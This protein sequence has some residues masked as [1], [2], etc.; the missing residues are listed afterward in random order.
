MGHPVEDGTMKRTKEQNRKNYLAWKA[1]LLD[2]ARL[3]GVSAHYGSAYG[4]RKLAAM[5]RMFK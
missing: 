1:R 2:W 4:L 5:R 3:N